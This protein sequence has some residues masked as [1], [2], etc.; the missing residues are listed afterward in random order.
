MK[1]NASVKKKDSTIRPG[2]MYI[3]TYRP[4]ALLSDTLLLDTL[5]NETED[6]IYFKDTESKFIL[7]N[8]KHL[9]Q[10]GVQNQEELIGKSD[11]DLYPKVFADKGLTAKLH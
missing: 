1:I 9:V 5:L 10:F 7:N 4:S 11:A 6:T 3:N 2:Y 8:R